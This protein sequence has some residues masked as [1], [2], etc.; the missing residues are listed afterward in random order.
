MPELLTI[1]ILGIVE[2]VT[3]FLPVSSTGHLILASR[4]LG[5]DPSYWELFNIAI[6]PGAILAIV[7]LYWRT[8]LTVLGG[9]VRGEPGAWRFVRN[10]VVAFLP[11]AALGV[12]LHDRIEAL[13]GS[14][15]TAA[16]AL[17]V[18]GLA[19]LAVE[20]VAKEGA[21]RGIAE[22][23]L[24]TAAGIGAVQCLALIPGVSRSASTILG[25][26]LLGVERR[27]AAEFSFFLGLPT[28]T[29]ATLY[30]LYKHRDALASG[31]GVG[32]G[33]IAI[34]AAVSF[35]VAVVVVRW[36]IGIV[37]KRGFAPFAWYRIALGGGAL[38]WLLA[39]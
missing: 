10:V 2:G 25:G 4:F 36:F 35:V 21:V 5:Y 22:I 13:L 14:A 30:Q 1:I 26:L 31:Q 15:E 38:I 28:L 29:G 24:G 16:W 20:R 17:L 6:Q 3:E 11:A 27:T 7:A 23:P 18:G 39:R 8:C 12:V 32:L 37:G 19:I 33:G 9:M 34:G